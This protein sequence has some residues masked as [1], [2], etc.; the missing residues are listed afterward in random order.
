MEQ[1]SQSQVQSDSQNTKIF[2]NIFLFLK[3]PQTKGQVRELVTPTKCIL[4]KLIHLSG[5][6]GM[7]SLIVISVSELH[8]DLVLPLPDLGGCGRSGGEVRVV[9]HKRQP[10]DEH[11]EGPG[12]PRG[13][14]VPPLLLHR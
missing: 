8:P 1:E 7:W 4:G 3:F 2:N 13:R 12:L 9:G 5:F 10:R 11:R 6:R 14:R